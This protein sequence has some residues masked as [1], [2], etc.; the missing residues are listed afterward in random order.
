MVNMIIT[1]I[2]GLL[3]QKLLE[4]AAS[5]YSILGIDIHPAPF[6][7]QIKFKYE[8]LDI[9]DR[10]LLTE[11]ILSFYPHYLINTAALTDVDG[12]EKNKEQ[13]WKI[14][15]HAVK[16]IVYAAR[17]IG[18]KIIHL[19]TDYIFDGNSS[20]YSE[21]DPP[22]PLGYYGKSKLASENAL[23]ASGLDYYSIVRTMV[24]YGVASNVRPN[25]VTWL[26]SALKENKKLKI[27]TDQLGSPTLAD[28]LAATILKIIELEKWDTF[29]VSGSEIIDR[30]KFA[31]RIAEVFGL[32]GS[33][34]SPIV[35]SDLKQKSPRP[36]NSG[37]NITKA[38]TELGVKLSNIEEGLKIFKKQFRN[39]KL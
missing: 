13:C 2:N 14:N 15:V 4:Q 20:P 11:S 21:N 27:V 9:T 25:F 24:L 38:T 18:T 36:L 17:K 23:H 32:E 1:G 10:R 3:G 5:K 8:Q 35:T 26:I 30:Y 29:H 37:F 6:N 22:S 12:C 33:L 39:K 16:N 31:L 19:S 28:D 34:I 7:K